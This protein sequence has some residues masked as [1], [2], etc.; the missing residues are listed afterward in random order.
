[1]SE[2]ARIHYRSDGDWQC[3]MVIRA[4][5]GGG[6]HGALYHSQSIEAFYAHVPGLK[7]VVPSTPA[8]AKGLLVSSIEDPDPVLFLEPKKLYRLAK[9]PYP[10]GDYRVPLG[11]AAVRRAGTDLTIVAYGTM[12]YYSLEAADILA[13]QGLSAEVVDLRSIKPLDWPTVEASL[14]KTGRLLIVHEDNEF[15]G[16]GAEIAAQASDKGFELLDAPVRRYATPDVPTFPF[17]SKLEEMVMPNTE[18][19]VRHALELAKY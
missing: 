4:P 1:V 14:A 13:E 8:D 3:P 12:S 18:G 16:F 2:V 9:G 10:A 11:R 19:I 7:V 6:I 17:A 15:V 5:Y